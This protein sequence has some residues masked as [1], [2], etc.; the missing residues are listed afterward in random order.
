MNGR[1][2][3][4]QDRLRPAVLQSARTVPIVTLVV[5]AIAI[6]LGFASSWVDVFSYQREAIAHGQVWRVAT[7][8]LT[9]WNADHLLWDVVMFVVL[10]CVVERRRRRTA[11][12]LLIGSGLLI[13][14]SLWH[15]AADVGEYRGLSGVDS[16]LF[17]Y[18]AIVLARDALAARRYALAGLVGLL[19]AGFVGK[20][21]YELVM[22]AT[23]FVDSHS[24]GFTPLPMVHIVGAAA[25]MALAAID[26]RHQA[27][28]SFEPLPVG[29]P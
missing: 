18:V 19:L 9:H 12:R 10:S 11:V 26:G 15:S 29:Q 17:A 22:G 6:A 27:S 2:P 7:G 14:L 5:A 20:I 16:A 3:T 25:G 8:H 24:A 28:R 13:S 23:L 1:I 21:A 4:S